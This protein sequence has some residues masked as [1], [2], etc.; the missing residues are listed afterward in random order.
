M[1]YGYLIQTH[2]RWGTQH[3]YVKVVFESA[4]CLNYV[5]FVGINNSKVHKY[6]ISRVLR[7][8]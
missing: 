8:M 2:Y 1:P 5:K 4:F 7:A 6:Q 3:K